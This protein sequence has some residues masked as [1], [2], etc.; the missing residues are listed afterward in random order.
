MEPIPPASAHNHAIVGSSDPI[1]PM[2]V[3]TIAYR[4]APQTTPLAP[5]PNLVPVAVASSQ[6]IILPRPAITAVRVAQTS[7]APAPVVVA[8]AEPAA[9]ASTTKTEPAKTQSAKAEPSKLPVPAAPLHVRGGWLIQIGA[10]DGE[11][12]AKQHLNEAQIKAPAVLA[13]ADPFTERV[14]KGDKALYRARFAGFDKTMAEAACK[15]LK[16]SDIE[17]MALKD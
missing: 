2:R 1:Q 4:T 16:R 10:F 15:Q 9:V 13:A 14:R 5:L 7:E 12:E 8:T 6:P 11:N 17:C 3:K